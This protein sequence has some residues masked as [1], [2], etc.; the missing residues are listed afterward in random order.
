LILSVV[1]AL[2]LSF[3]C[4]EEES[5]ERQLNLSTAREQLEADFRAWFNGSWRATYEISI[6]GD[7]QNDEQTVTWFKQDTT[8]QRFDFEGTNFG[9][10]FEKV[11][12]FIP[13]DRTKTILCSPEIP[14][15][16]NDEE[17]V[18]DKGACCDGPT[19]CGDI[20]GNFVVNARFQLEFPKSVLDQDVDFADVNIVEFSERTIAGVK[21]RCY[22]IQDEPSEFETE[23]ERVSVSC[24]GDGGVELY[25]D[26]FDIDHI[27][28][29]ATDV[30][31]GV[32][33]SDFDTPYPVQHGE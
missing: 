1:A 27:T 10:A 3:G 22:T 29:E 32:A 25:R 21:A 16:P 8:Q 12:V 7:N 15:D 33:D 4:G 19:G 31:L 30:Q 11:Q 23:E 20:G 17:G 6:E 5:Q 26:V 2:A 13:G 14:V 18:G 9:E 28:A 24:F